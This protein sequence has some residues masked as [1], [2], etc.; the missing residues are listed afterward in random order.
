[1]NQ[2]KTYQLE[3]ALLT[4]A[5]F[6]VMGWHDCPIH[7]ISFDSDSK[8]SFDIDYIFE[9]VRK[10]NQS[11]FKFW[12]APCTLMFEYVYEIELMSGNL[13]IV[14]LGISRTASGTPEINGDAVYDWLIETTSGEISFKSNG[15]KQYVRQAPILINDQ[16]IDKEAR[17][18]ISFSLD[19]IKI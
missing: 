7:A 1:M 16:E 8:M 19:S 4:N 13:P 2:T 6:D 5:D 9:W 18:G 3:K 14:I 15:F 17:G 12:I 11:Y 10:E